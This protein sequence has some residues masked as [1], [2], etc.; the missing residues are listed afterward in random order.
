MNIGGEKHHQEQTFPIRLCFMCLADEGDSAKTRTNNEILTSWSTRNVNC[1][2][3]QTSRSTSSKLYS[4]VAMS[5]FMATYATSC[6]F[7]HRHDAQKTSTFGGCLSISDL[8]KEVQPYHRTA[9]TKRLPHYIVNNFVKMILLKMKQKSRKFT[10]AHSYWNRSVNCTT[11]SELGVW[12]EQF[13]GNSECDMYNMFSPKLSK[14]F[15]YAIQWRIYSGCDMSCM[16]DTSITS[17]SLEHGNN[18]FTAI[19]T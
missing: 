8:W 16:A 13:F 19:E 9:H 1:H 12:S 14:T 10:P 11:S 4:W 6:M 17:N 15:S 7:S 3:R 5:H 18:A 2:R